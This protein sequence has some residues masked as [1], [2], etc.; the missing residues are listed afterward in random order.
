MP[1]V[2]LTRIG[3]VHLQGPSKAGGPGFQVGPE[4][5]KTTL[6]RRSENSPGRRL[7]KG[8]E[9]AENGCR[10]G[11]G[12]EGNGHGIPPYPPCPR[13]L[14]G[15]Y[16]WHDIFRPDCAQ[17]IKRCKKPGLPERV[18]TNMQAVLR[19]AWGGLAKGNQA[20]QQ[21]EPSVVSQKFPSL[22]R[23][24]SGA[25]GPG[26]GAGASASFVVLKSLLVGGAKGWE[27]A[28]T[29]AAEVGA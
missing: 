8:W 24:L 17:E 19:L 20:V 5:F 26:L 16:D 6:F 9:S 29:A 28:E 1:F 22:G 10:G 21:A 7:A 14:R 15:N 11:G 12:L 18:R 3:W 25:W 27:T 4:S 2:Q 13:F 23:G